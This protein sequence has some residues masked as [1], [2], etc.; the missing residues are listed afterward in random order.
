[1]PIMLSH[2]RL[3]SHDPR[4][5]NRR[6]AATQMNL[7]ARLYAANESPSRAAAETHPLVELSNMY[8]TRRAMHSLRP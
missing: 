7:K 4:D 2:C 5:P 3:N 6:S 1:M 8:G